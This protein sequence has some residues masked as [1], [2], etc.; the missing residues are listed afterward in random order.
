MPQPK[1]DYKEI[2][3]PKKSERRREAVIDQ[4]VPLRGWS[5]LDV[6]E[7]GEWLNS[8]TPIVALCLVHTEEFD[9]LSGEWQ[10]VTTYGP[11][12]QR[13]APLLLGGA[14]VYGDS[15][16]LDDNGDGA[17]CGENGFV[18]YAPDSSPTSEWEDQRKEHIKLLPQKKASG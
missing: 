2:M 14:C 15:F 11:D 3:M 9:P 18:A 10:R 4:I 7:K 12:R 8:R 17:P 1:P 6:D 16:E 13:V 5:R